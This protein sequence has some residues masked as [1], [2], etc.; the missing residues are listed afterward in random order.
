M[1]IKSNLFGIQN[2]HDNFSETTFNWV[3]VRDFFEKW[4]YFFLFSFYQ[5]YITLKISFR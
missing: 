4:F 2:D 1:E 3:Q 5:K